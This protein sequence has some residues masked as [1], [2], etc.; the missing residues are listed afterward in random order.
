MTNTLNKSNAVGAAAIGAIAGATAVLATGTAGLAV[1]TS[2]AEILAA[3]LGSGIVGTISGVSANL[4]LTTLLNPS[5]QLP[6]R[7]PNSVCP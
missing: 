3:P 5:S 4:G 7:Q 2:F 1:A 6:S